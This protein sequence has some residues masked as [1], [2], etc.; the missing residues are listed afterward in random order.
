MLA[1]FMAAYERLVL[2]RPL[3]ALLGCLLLLVALGSQL[4]NLKLD[5]SSDS[6]VLEGD[7]AL[8]YYRE[9]SSLY[10]AEEF[11]VIT[12]QPHGDLLGDE[13]LET[14]AALRDELAALDGVSS[15]TTLLDVP[16]LESPPVSLSDVTGDE[17]LPELGSPGIDREL[18]RKEFKNSPIYAQLLVSPDGRTAAIQVNLDRDFV[19][20]ELLQ[21]RESLRKQEAAGGLSAQGVRELK[22]AELEFKAHSALVL[23]RQ[24]EFIQQVR[25]VVAQ[26][27]DRADLFVG[28]VPMI[29]ADMISFVKSDLITF[30]GGILLFMVVILASIFRTLRWV[31]LPVLTCVVTTVFMLGLLAWLDWRM[32]VISSNFVALLLIITLAISI[33]LVVRFRELELDKPDAG[34]GELVADMVRLMA[35][36]CLYTTLTTAVA[37][38]S[39]VVSGIRPVMDFGWMMTIGISAALLLTFIV[40][41]CTLALMPRGKPGDSSLRHVGLTVQFAHFTER[42]SAL[43]IPGSLLL[44]AISI[45]G[46]SKLEVENRF[47]DYF[48]ESTEIYQ[49]MELLD[50]ELGGTIPLDII[51][52]LDP[53]EKNPEFAEEPDSALEYTP[54]EAYQD[55][56]DEESL[57]G[58]GDE[59]GDDEFEGEFD[60]GFDEVPEGAGDAFRQS[61]WFTVR[62]MDR[63]ETIHNYV[64]SLPETGKV[65]SLATTYAVVKKMLG[66]DISDVELALVQKSLPGPVKDLMVAP[67]FV[68]DIEQARITLRVKET[69]RE[70]RRDEFLKNLHTHLVE[71]L[72]VK[73]EQLHFTGLLVMYN[74]MLQSLFKSQILTLGAVFIAIMLMFMILFRSFSLALIAVIPNILAASLVLGGMGLAGIPLDMMTITIAAIVV[75]IGVDDTIHYVHRFRVEFPLDSNYTAAMYRCHE[76][77]GRAMFYTS[78]TIIMG[79]SILALSNF[80]P[81]IHFGLLTGLAMLVAVLGAL[82]LLPQLIR[83]FKPLGPELEALQ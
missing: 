46:I 14:I 58:G 34:Q 56:G 37:F 27:R 83:T 71:E 38:V 26:Y 10:D 54:T 35:V 3:L 18:V 65:L 76:S 4:G 36:P 7:S 47:I 30:G 66:E 45:W 55:W 6:L 13:S 73:E 79:F 1:A 28:G 31:L 43:I 68:E 11:V 8:A 49:G 51:L 52:D 70:L 50:A 42:F 15:V 82:I 39:L 57:D 12:F 81:S 23:E 32:T 77:I 33:H 67:Y 63:L 75:G 59:W 25:N 29:A 48:H 21:I 22:V 41:P 53:L 80:K 5:A 9:I 78:V 24:G 19:Y 62:G 20:E 40:L 64:D 44:A 17:P 2:G 72:G 74:N 60:S 61:Y 69:S 16:L